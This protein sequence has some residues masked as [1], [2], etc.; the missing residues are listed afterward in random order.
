MRG[1]C[2]TGAWA[3]GAIKALTSYSDFFGMLRSWHND[4]AMG[5]MGAMDVDFQRL[6]LV[7]VTSTEP[8]MWIDNPHQSPFNVGQTLTL[9]DFTLD[10]VRHLNELHAMPI[11]DADGIRLHKLVGGH[12]YLVC[13]A[14]HLI[15][16][17]QTSPARLFEQACRQEGP[18]AEHLQRFLHLFEKYAE[19]KVGMRQIIAGKVCKDARVRARLG[20]AGLVREEG[21]R[22]VPRCKLYADYFREHLH[23]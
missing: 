15:A 23:G 11:S 20:G 19:L 17:E 3:I 6:D 8:Q 1:N 16:T 4:R 21:R 2:V 9:E 18:F 10:Q 13:L 7:L 14:Y 22:T 12:P 5:A